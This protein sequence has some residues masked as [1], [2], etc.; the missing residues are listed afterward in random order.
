MSSQLGSLRSVSPLLQKQ[1]ASTTLTIAEL[2]A[3]M[4]KYVR[5]VIQY[6]DGNLASVGS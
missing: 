4:E 2:T 5:F 6:M 1:F 3:L